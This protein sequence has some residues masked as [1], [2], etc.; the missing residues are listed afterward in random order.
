MKTLHTLIIF[1][2]KKIESIRNFDD[3]D[4]AKHMTLKF[5]KENIEPTLNSFDDISK[6]ITDTDNEYSI[7]LN[8]TSLEV[9]DFEKT[10]YKVNNVYMS[11]KD[12]A[13]L[14]N[15][16]SDDISD[17]QAWSNED[18]P[19]EMIEELVSIGKEV[20]ELYVYTYRNGEKEDQCFVEVVI[21]NNIYDVESTTDDGISIICDW[22]D[23]SEM[24]EG[25]PF[26]YNS[27]DGSY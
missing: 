5:A 21:E 7:S 4:Y 20:E 10:P 18:T 2:N 8:E 14:L 19:K 6:F 12:M 11:K 1:K 9:Q 26:S 22:N 15:S 27:S 24:W 13:D 23:H 16:L 17:D 25:E 3:I